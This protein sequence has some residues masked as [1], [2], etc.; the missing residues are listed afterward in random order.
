MPVT[1]PWKSDGGDKFRQI[2]ACLPGGDRGKF[3]SAAHKNKIE[4]HKGIC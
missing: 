2:I 3:A 4:F 1:A